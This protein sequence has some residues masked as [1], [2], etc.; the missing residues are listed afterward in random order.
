[1][2]NKI[3]AQSTFQSYTKLH[4][5]INNEPP[6]ILPLL[7]FLCFLLKILDRLV[8]KLLCY[9]LV[10]D[11]FYF[12]ICCHL[13]ISGKLKTYIVLCEQY[14]SSLIR[15]PSYTEYLDKIGQLFFNVKPIERRPIQ[16]NGFLGRFLF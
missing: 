15:D 9:C 13:F 2:R 16:P 14:Q 7:N 5:A 8:I 3:I 1:M 12:C 10:F 4:P 11:N 6:Y